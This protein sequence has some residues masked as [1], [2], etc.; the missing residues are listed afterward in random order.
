VQNGFVVGSAIS[1]IKHPSMTGTK[2]LVVQPLMADRTSA[3]GYPVLAVDCVG[4]GAGET[5]MISS[6][7]RFVRDLLNSD[8][9]PVR[10]AVI[11][12]EDE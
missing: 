12:I 1:T 9:T 7:G 11:G 5:V 8:S 6:D 4:A 3:D 2:M 10:W